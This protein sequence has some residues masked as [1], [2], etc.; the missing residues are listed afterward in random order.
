MQLRLIPIASVVLSGCLF[1]FAHAA[2]KRSLTIEEI[3]VTARKQEESSQDIPIA[4]TAISQELQN[5]T[6][7]NLTDLTGFAP[8]VTIG[9]DGS[10]GGGGAVI[11]IRGISPTRTDDNSFDAPIGVMIDGIYLGSLAG[12]V[13]ENFDLERVEVLRGPQGTLFGKNTVGGVINV[14]RSRPT[15]EFGARVKATLG[16]DGQQELRAVVNTPL[17][18]NQLAAKFF[19]TSIEDDGFMKNITI[20]GNTGETDYMNYG[21]TFLWTPNDRFEATFTAER[22][23]DQSQLSSFNTNYNAAPGVLDPP[24]DPND[25][26]FTGGFLTCIFFPANG[27]R[28]S[29]ATPKYSENDTENQAELVTDAFTLNMKYELNENLT[30]V[31]TTGYRQMDEYRIYDFDGS[32]APFITIERWN[33]YD[34][35]S[36]ELRIDG[37]YENF[38]FTTGLYYFQNEFEQDW[39]TGGQFWGILFG[40][41]LSPQ[42]NW[43]A[44]QADVN[45]FGVACDREI[46]SYP[47]NTTSLAQILF[48][49]QETTSYAV[50]AQGDWNFAE[51]WTLTA[52]IRWTREEK[53][54]IAGQAYLTAIERQ[55]NRAHYDFANLDKT[56]TEVSPKI[57]LTYRLNDD[58]I[59]Y[60]SYSEGFHSGGFFGVNQN[61]R[62]FNRDQYEPEIS[63][64]Y[65]LGYKATLLNNRLLLN[66]SLFQNDFIDKQEASV[67]VDP[68]TQTVATVFS[69]AADAEYKGYELET[70]FVV[71]ENLRVFLNYGYLDASYDEFFTDINTSD[72]QTIIE[73]ASFLTPRNAPKYTIGLGGTATFQIGQGN[74]EIYTKWT[75]ID[76]VESNLL[77]T[78]L[79][80]VAKREDLTAS[81]GYFTENWSVVAFGINL[82]DERIE[83][84]TPVEPLFAVGSLNQGRRYG[85]ELSYSF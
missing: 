62:D 39:A 43:E 24:T 29:K 28:T 67:Q 1:S 20:G 69:N 30:L 45:I 81:I 4:M 41:A 34:Q 85:V 26:D 72:G 65:E 25:S 12:Q 61:V 17:V 3:T 74:L 59:V 79:G 49:T 35:F 10:R 37:K 58:A 31:S 71:N 51:N 33:E 16:E 73:D 13:L 53:D 14:I 52:G 18:E 32:A 23:D 8:N 15:G 70:Q 2:E 40:P 83:V 84:F 36:E 63:E 64:S 6:V 46:A 47:T 55:R 77:N 50:F 82:T 19:A 42:P 56:W 21:A 38:S 60:G 80:R 9:R 78:D 75:E 68:T 44:C 11:N 57:G 7:R 48:E 76:E 54:F 27:C 5:S 22:F 66:V